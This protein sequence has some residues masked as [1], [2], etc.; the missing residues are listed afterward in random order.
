MHQAHRGICVVCKLSKGMGGD[1]WKMPRGRRGE[2]DV[3]SLHRRMERGLLLLISA[4]WG[5]LGLGYSL[6][7]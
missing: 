2:D 1:K 4:F 7:V 6:T 5:C 3:I